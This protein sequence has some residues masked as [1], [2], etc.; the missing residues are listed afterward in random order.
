MPIA[1]T[2]LEILMG[3]FLSQWPQLVDL[4]TA[5]DFALRDA[6]VGALS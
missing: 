4:I 6:I 5:G 2:Q 3:V 1:N